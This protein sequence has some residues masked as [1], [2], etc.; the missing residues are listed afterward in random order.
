MAY[1]DTLWQDSEQIQKSKYCPEGD[2]IVCVQKTG[3]GDGNPL[4]RFVF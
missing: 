1:I 2:F 4:N 3:Q